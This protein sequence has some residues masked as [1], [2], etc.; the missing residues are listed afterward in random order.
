MTML[1]T[2]F[3]EQAKKTKDISQIN[4]MNYSVSY[5]TGFPPLD[6]ANGY[7]Q[8]VNNNLRLEVGIS[9]GSINMIISDSG[10]GKTTICTQIACNIVKNFKTSTIFYEQAEVGTNIQRIKNLSGFRSDEEFR[11]RFVIRDSGITIESIYERVRMVHDIKVENPDDYLYDTGMVD[12]GGNEIYKFE[13]TIFVVDSVKMVMSQKNTESE[14]TNNM[15]GATNAKANSEYYTKMVPLCREA[16]IIMFLIN[17]ITVDVNTGFMLKKPEFPY[18]KVNEH[19][20]GGKSLAYIQNNIFRLDI[21]SKLKD[22]EGFGITGSIINID[23]VKSRTNKTSRARC[24]L[25]FNQEIGYDADLSLMLMLKEEK[26]L[27]GAGAYLR[28]PNSEKKFSQKAFKSL[29][30]SDPEFRAEFYKVCFDYLTNSLIEEYNRIKEDETK[31][32]GYESPYQA[33]LNQ[34]NSNKSS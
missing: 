17:H 3:R 18:L 6:F 9:D 2:V 30:Y 8:E 27:E 21:K 12:M 5:A 20:S 28:L 25:V 24:A 7:V 34:F 15:T 11:N 16:N 4:E 29:L 33:L 32:T 13:P 10:L 31:Q 22:D 23:I 26:I 19:L 14:L 1:A